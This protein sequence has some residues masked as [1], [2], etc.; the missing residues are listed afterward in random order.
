MAA[1]PISLWCGNDFNLYSLA[2]MIRTIII[3][4]L[5]IH[6]IRGWQ[7]NVTPLIFEGWWRYSLQ[8]ILLPPCSFYRHSSYWV[9]LS[10]SLL[11]RACEG[12]NKGSKF[13]SIRRGRVKA[14]WKWY[15]SFSREIFSFVE[16]FGS[17]HFFKNCAPYCIRGPN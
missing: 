8:H 17:K 7:W 13:N 2:W 4:L 15:Y 9:A 11:A 6:F 10:A 3:L 12:C 14:A 16:F 5:L 1:M